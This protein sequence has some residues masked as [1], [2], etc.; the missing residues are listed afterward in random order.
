MSWTIYLSMGSNLEDRGANLET[1]LARLE[2][3]SIVPLVCSSIFET[4]AVEKVDQPD[5]L[6]LVCSAET[7][8]V[9]QALLETC[10]E[11]EADMGRIRHEPKGPRKIDIDILFHG[12]SIVDEPHLKIPHPA[13]RQRNFVLIPMEEIAPD[14]RD[15]LTGKTIR[16]LRLA[17]ADP[18]K[19]VRLDSL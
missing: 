8:M 6:N 11:I 16:E 18:A 10:Q 5:F 13:L 17:C 12:E 19:V 7:G 1:A 3:R 14:F 4:E 2:A 15:P 9:P